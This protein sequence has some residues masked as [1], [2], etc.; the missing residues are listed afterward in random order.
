MNTEDYAR[1]I[2]NAVLPPLS[3]LEVEL[4]VN[5]RIERQRVFSKAQPTPYVGYVHELALRMQFGG[6]KTTRDQLEHLCAVSEQ[7]HVLLRVIPTE[8]GSF[9]GAGHALLY[10]EGV[11]RELDTVQLDSAH[12]PEFLHAEAQLSKYRA[13]LSWMD[14]HALSPEKTRDLIHTI[15]SEL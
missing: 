15:A 7:G 11:I 2:F 4:R 12:G 14:E 13:H 5:F 10:A 8:S 1:S 9:P 6:R 3:R